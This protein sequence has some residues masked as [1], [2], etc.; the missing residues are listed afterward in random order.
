M[1][2]RDIRLSQAAGNGS[3]VGTSTL[4][5]LVFWEPCV[6]PHMSAFIGAVA[7]AL[8]PAVDVLCVAHEDVPQDRQ[9]LG[10]HSGGRYLPLQDDIASTVFW[11]QADPHGAFPKLPGKDALEVN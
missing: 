2:T 4:A 9:A 6:S 1:T 5:R 7:R 8:G 11:Y 3:G 10:W